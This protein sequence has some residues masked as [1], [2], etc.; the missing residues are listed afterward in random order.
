MRDKV[1][2]AAK[3]YHPIEIFSVSSDSMAVAIVN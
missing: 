2:R 3:L 1:R